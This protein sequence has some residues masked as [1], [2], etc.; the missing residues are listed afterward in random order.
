MEILFIDASKLLE[1]Y[2]CFW[3]DWYSVVITDYLVCFT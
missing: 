2:N 1:V 3:L